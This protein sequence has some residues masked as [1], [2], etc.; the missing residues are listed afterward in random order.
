[1]KSYSYPLFVIL[2]G[3][4]FVFALIHRA[5][6]SESPITSS[7]LTLAATPPAE[8][9]RWQVAP[10]LMIAERGGEVL[11]VAGLAT[12]ELNS[13]SPRNM[14]DYRYDRPEKPEAV[15]VTLTTKDGKRWRAKWEE[16]PNP[17]SSP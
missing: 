9:A 8:T 2:T 14:V 4:L 5:S 17:K 10:T 1:M 12:V 11:L 13:T 7:G 3:I 15:V 16:I 6:G